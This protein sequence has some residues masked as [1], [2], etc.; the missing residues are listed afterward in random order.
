MSRAISPRYAAVVVGAG[1]AGV[2][3]L[4]N[5]LELGLTKIAWVDPSFDGGRVNR[6]YREVPSNT[7]VSFFQ[8]FATG[9]QPF[10]N[11]IQKTPTPNAFTVMNKLEQGDTCSLHYAAD[12]CR[13][14][15]DGLLNLDQ[16]SQYRGTVVAADLKEKTSNWAVNIRLQDPSSNIE[17]IT[18]RLILCTGSS[19]SSPALPIS[20]LSM[21][22]L[23][24]DTVLKPS[25]L[26][27][28]IPRN[29]ATTVA[30]IG[31]SHSA[32]LALLNLFDLARTTH[33]NLR[34]KWFTRHPL[35]Y[36]EFM[37]GWILRDNTGLKGQAAQ[38]AREQLEDSRLPSSAAGRFI[39]KIDTS[40][41]KE[42]A[43]YEREFPACTHIVYAIGYKTD[44]LPTLTRNGKLSLNN[45]LEWDSQFGG[46]VDGQGEVVPGLHGAGIAFPE[47][48][49]DPLGNVEHAVGFFKFMKFL[50]RV[51]PQWV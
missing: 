23:D 34:I 7:K 9:A 25:V 11:I 12:M 13:A 24:L 28:Q 15:T 6:K 16:V 33:P 51:A 5:L 46:F 47:R 3:A 21:E 38:F 14:L 1:P 22:P 42:A 44:P 2:A 50:K 35:R 27:E 26:Y 18:P 41:N 4:G 49:V 43:A 30:V 40:N 10:R 39:E 36:A 29:E 48:V 19:P 31:A 20:G 8:A 45:K 32:I 37:D 17:V